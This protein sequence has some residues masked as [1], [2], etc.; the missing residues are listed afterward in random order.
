MAA[1]F[2][3]KLKKKLN[4]FFLNKLYLLT[5]YCHIVNII[6]TVLPWFI[7]SVLYISHLCMVGPETFTHVYLNLNLNLAPLTL[8]ANQNAQ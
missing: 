4:F 2:G 1:K 8:L 3:G 5:P 6:D 7:N